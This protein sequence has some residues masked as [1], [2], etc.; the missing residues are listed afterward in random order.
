[1]MKTLLEDD[2]IQT[3]EGKKK[4]SQ[5]ACKKKE[6]EKGDFDRELDRRGTTVLLDKKDVSGGIDSKLTELLCKN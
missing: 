1:M 5:A 4:L 6:K 3:K 2:G